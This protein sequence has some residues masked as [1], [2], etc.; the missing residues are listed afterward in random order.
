MARPPRG[1]RPSAAPRF[2]VQWEFAPCWESCRQFLGIF[3]KLQTSEVTISG[4][5]RWCQCVPSLLLQTVPPS[6][7]NT[8]TA[9]SS[10]APEVSSFGFGAA[11]SAADPEVNSILIALPAHCGLTFFHFLPPLRLRKRLPVLSRE[12]NRLPLD[13][14]CAIPTPD[15]SVMA[16][17]A[18][19]ISAT[20]WAPTLADSVCTAA[21]PL[22]AS[23]S[24]TSDAAP[25]SSTGCSMANS[26]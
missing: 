3:G 26:L 25:T 5:Y 24:T 10:A 12:R 7:V 17:C 14:V 13:T 21:A 20:V 9:A 18:P 2:V 6:V 22:P 11:A 16:R 23:T 8:K 19:F 15:G 4:S 1:K